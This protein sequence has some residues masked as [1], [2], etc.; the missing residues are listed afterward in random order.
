[1]TDPHRQHL[2]DAAVL[3]A[4]HRYRLARRAWRRLERLREPTLEQIE[5]R[6]DAQQEFADAERSLL[7]IAGRE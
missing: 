7:E 2:R 6:L 1:M 3:A 5:E 4:V